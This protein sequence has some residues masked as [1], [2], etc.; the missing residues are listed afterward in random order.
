MFYRDKNFDEFS[1]HLKG[2]VNLYNLPGDK[3]GV[4]FCLLNHKVLSVPVTCIAIFF[5]HLIPQQIKDKDVLGTSV[6]G[7]RPHKDDAYV[8]VQWFPCQ[9]KVLD[10]CKGPG[11]TRPSRAPYFDINLGI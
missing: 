5:S 6:P 7:V 1:K 4:H 8:Q 11:H 9:Q 3:Y 2:L 10:D